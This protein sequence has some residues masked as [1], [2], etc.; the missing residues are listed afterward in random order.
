MSPKTPEIPALPPQPRLPDPE[1][2]AI[3]EKQKQAQAAILSRTGRR[4]TILT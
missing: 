4:S 3:K 2:P 1:D